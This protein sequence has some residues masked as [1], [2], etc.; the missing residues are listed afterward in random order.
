MTPDIVK[1][2]VFAPH[3]SISQT[4]SKGCITRGEI[5]DLPTAVMK[6]PKVTID[7]TPETPKMSSLMKNVM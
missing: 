2:T 4:V 5:L 7:R 6:K 3:S 1:M